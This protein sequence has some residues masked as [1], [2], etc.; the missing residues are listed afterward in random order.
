MAESA[1]SLAIAFILLLCFLSPHTCCLKSF[2]PRVR[3]DLLLMRGK[4]GEE[5]ESVDVDD[6]DDKA[7]VE[8]D[9]ARKGS[10]IGGVCTG[11]GVGAGVESGVGA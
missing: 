1:E 3:L 2:H 8:P 6:T 10:E 7:L 5:R 4:K 9:V 11:T